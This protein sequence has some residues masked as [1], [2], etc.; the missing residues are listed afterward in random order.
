MNGATTQA[1]IYGIF[2]REGLDFGARWTTPDPST[3]TYKAMKLYR[4][5]DGAKSTFGDTSVAATVPN[6]DSL[7]AF[8]AV[9]SSDGALTLML[10]N[11]DPANATPVT[12]NLASFASSGVAHA[13][14]LTSA[15][16]TAHLADTSLSGASLSVT[17]P[18]QSVTLYV[19]PPG[20]GTA[21]K[22]PVAVV[23][24]SPQTGVAPLAVAFDGGGSSDPDGTIASSSWSF[25][26]GTTG[27]GATV[28]H[29][30]TAVG[31]YTAKL[32]VT[33]NAGA[34]ASATVAIGATTDPNALSAP[35]GLAGSASRTRVVTLTWTDNSGNE[36]G[37][38]VERA[39][40]GSTAFARVGQVGANVRTWAQSTA[41]GRWAFRVQAFNATTGRVSAFSSTVTIRVK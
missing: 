8:A 17:V 6:P 5:Y 14:Q 18:A 23:S 36:T 1:D 22:P 39:P 12:V 41:A 30:Y 24:A 35:S 2:G 37:F 40:A 9:R 13:W 32:T 28:S 27:S 10:I 3:P 33:D 7:A 19:I 20:S 15:N 26:D 16:A 38:F 31:S 11:K 25:G 34:T 21:N 29:T 4:N